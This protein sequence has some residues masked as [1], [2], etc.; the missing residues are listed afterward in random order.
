M[1]KSTEHLARQEPLRTLTVETPS[2]ERPVTADLRRQKPRF[3]GN[4]KADE[5]TRTLD[6]C[7]AR[8]LRQQTATAISRQ[9]ACYAVAPLPKVTGD[10]SNRQSNLATELANRALL[11]RSY[12][13]GLRLSR[14]KATD[15]AWDFARNRTKLERTECDASDEPRPRRGLGSTVLI[16]AN[17]RVLLGSESCRQSATRPCLR[18]CSCPTAPSAE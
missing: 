16:A 14:S 3:R 7:M 12:G 5:G 11:R 9:S 17:S 8:T 6:F 1:D 10:D 13:L 18:E 4:L 15:D 2:M